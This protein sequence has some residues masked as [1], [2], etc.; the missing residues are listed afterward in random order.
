MFDDTYLTSEKTVRP[1]AAVAAG[2]PPFSSVS[3]RN[4]FGRGGNP[5]VRIPARGT[6]YPTTICFPQT[7]TQTQLI[8]MKIKSSTP[9]TAIQDNHAPALINSQ[10][11][12]LAALLSLL[13]L[14]FLSGCASEAI[15]AGDIVSITQRTFGVKVGQAPANG[16]PEVTLGLI[17]TTVQFTPTSTNALYSPKYA[18]TFK[19]GQSAIPFTFD[20]DETIASGD[21][22]TGAKTNLTSVP[23]IPANG[24]TQ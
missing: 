20:V 23:I 24:P 10:L 13:W 15:R 8:K 7:K 11:R 19:I 17:A 4:N 18:N 16:S 21:V 5:T 3:S 14:P 2:R 12:S 22:Q 9:T 6:S 1:A